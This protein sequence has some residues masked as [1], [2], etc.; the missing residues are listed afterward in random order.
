[1][2]DKISFPAAPAKLDE[3]GRCCGKKPLSYKRQT[4]S[5]IPGP[6]FFCHRCCRAFSP[7][8]LQ[9]ENWAYVKI[10]GGFERRPVLKPGGEE[11]K[12]NIEDYKVSPE[13]IQKVLDALRDKHLRDMTS[14]GRNPEKYESVCT[15]AQ[16]LIIDLTARLNLET[17][18]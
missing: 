11:M 9:I 16:N 13:R 10:P 1:V 7:D 8:G 15:L 4:D 2:S 6:H 5:H 12:K 14:L 3:K 17:G 18:K